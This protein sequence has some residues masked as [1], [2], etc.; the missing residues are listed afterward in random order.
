M[1]IAHDYF[2]RPFLLEVACAQP[3]S[4]IRHAAISRRGHTMPCAIIYAQKFTFSRA[5]QMSD[6]LMTSHHN[7][8]RQYLARTFM[9]RRQRSDALQ[10][11]RPLHFTMPASLEYYYQQML[12]H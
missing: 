3:G 4:H 6:S 12:W 10:H 9:I 11:I 8:A 2:E 1:E 5:E 7:V